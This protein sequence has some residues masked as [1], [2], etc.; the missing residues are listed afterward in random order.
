MSE[1][2]G[3]ALALGALF[4][5]IALILLI[6]SSRMRRGK[7][8]P[9]PLIGIRTSA[10][11]SSPEAWYVGHRAAAGGVR[12]VAAAFAVTGV[13]CAVAGALGVP[14]GG[15]AAIILAG[16]GIAVI[17][18]LKAS[19]TARRAIEDQGLLRSR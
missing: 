12:W 5:I 15:I 1:D 18:L 14:D 4:E 11:R 10:T 9:N 16:S 17:L 13:G 8:R 2:L 6:L 3:S 19:V 7:L